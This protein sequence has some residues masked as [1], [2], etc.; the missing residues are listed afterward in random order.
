L[1][2]ALNAAAKVI[3]IAAPKQARLRTDS[4]NAVKITA[5]LLVAVLQEVRF[6]SRYTADQ[7]AAGSH[8]RP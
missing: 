1:V 8:E 6:P 2:D 7:P 4:A 3:A 5:A